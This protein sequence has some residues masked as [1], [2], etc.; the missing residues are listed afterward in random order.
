MLL[1]VNMEQV[2]TDTKNNRAANE[3]S[4]PEEEG[5]EP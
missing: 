3:L 1:V 2:G 5:E 4:E